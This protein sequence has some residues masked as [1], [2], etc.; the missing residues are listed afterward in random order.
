MNELSMLHDSY[1]NHVLTNGKRPHNVFAFTQSISMNEADFYKHYAS[2][3]DLERGV[4]FTWY[5]TIIHEFENDEAFES[6]GAQEKYLAFLFAVVQNFKQHRSFVVWWFNRNSKPSLVKRNAKIEEVLNP[7]F[8]KIVTKGLASAELMQIP[9]IDDK[10][11]HAM[12]WHLQ[13]VLRFWINDN[14]ADFEQTDAFIEKSA[15]FAFQFLGSG[16]VKS[17]LDLG[18]FMF[19]NWKNG[20]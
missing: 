16:I 8:Q 4:F 6:F 10:Y 14:S 17:G 1:M 5:K 19:Q 3:V 20:K 11:S 9:G 2:F 18:K 12:L 7:F 13:G 15:G